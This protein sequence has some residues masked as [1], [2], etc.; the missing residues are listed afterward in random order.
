MSWEEKNQ[1]FKRQTNFLL[2]NMQTF[3]KPRNL[4]SPLFFSLSHENKRIH[5]IHG[6]TEIKSIE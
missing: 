6:M 1:E 4:F 2:E 5:I 3:A